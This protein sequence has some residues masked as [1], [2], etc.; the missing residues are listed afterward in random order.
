MIN[1]HQILTECRLRTSRSSGSG[2]QHVNKVETR[3]ELLWNPSKSQSLTDFQRE[4]LIRALAT[5]LND[6]GDLIVSCQ[7][8]RSQSMNRKRAEEKLISLIEKAMRPVKRRI[9]TKKSRGQNEARLKSK[10]RRSETKSRRR[11]RDSDH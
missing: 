1:H 3:V 11:F 10:A 8:S 6:D 7:E 4:K 5:K 9:P 2:G